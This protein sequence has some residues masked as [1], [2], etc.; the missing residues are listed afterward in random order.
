MIECLYKYNG[1]NV[2]KKQIISVKK[3]RPRIFNCKIQNEKLSFKGYL[4]RMMFIILTNAKLQ[5]YYVT[6]DNQEV[7]HTSYVIPKCLKFRFMKKGDIEIGPCFTRKDFRG[8]GI[9]P[10]VLS[11]IVEENGPDKNYYMLV[12]EN[13]TASKRGMEKAGF[14]EI[15]KVQCSGILKIRKNPL[16][17]T[18]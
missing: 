13:N 2:S 1:L 15:G 18:P 11:C 9:Y 3:Y 7:V 17:T 16:H 12:D 8:K 14:E 5:V 10:T 4:V 6:N